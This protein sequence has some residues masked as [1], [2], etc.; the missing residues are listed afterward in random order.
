MHSLQE[1]FYNFGTMYFYVFVTSY[2]FEDE[3]GDD[4]DDW[5]DAYEYCEENH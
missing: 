3:W 1:M 2:D 4:F 5:E